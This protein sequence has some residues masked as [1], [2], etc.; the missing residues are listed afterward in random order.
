MVNITRLSQCLKTEN[1]TSTD[2]ANW[3]EIFLDNPIGVKKRKGFAT[4]QVDDISCALM[5]R[6]D[7]A[8]LEYIDIDD[9]EDIVV[10]DSTNSLDTTTVP[11]IYTDYT[12]FRT[13]T[14]KSFPSEAKAYAK[15]VLAPFS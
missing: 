6:A 5:V 14:K 1:Y 4:Y 3:T 12:A 11:N 7:G 13:E 8:I 15:G 9:G 10:Q 2:V